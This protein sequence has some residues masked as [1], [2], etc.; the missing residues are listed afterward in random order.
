MSSKPDRGCLAFIFGSREVCKVTRDEGYSSKPCPRCFERTLEGWKPAVVRRENAQRQHGKGANELRRDTSRRSNKKWVD[1]PPRTHGK[2]SEVQRHATTARSSTSRSHRHRDR[3]HRHHEGTATRKHGAGV[4][5]S[6]I[7]RGNAV[8]Y[9][10][11]PLA[12]KGTGPYITTSVRAVSPTG[13]N[14]VRS[15][16]ID[17]PPRAYTVS[18][19]NDADFD[20]ESVDISDCDEYPILRHA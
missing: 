9:D 11:N 8:K 10:R 3:E 17:V 6:R 20:C 12:R 14:T 1:V 7:Q 19:L 16:V 13:Q 15:P 18:P 5:G 2:H 4:P